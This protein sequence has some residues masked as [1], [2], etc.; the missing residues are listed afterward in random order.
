MTKLKNKLWILLAGA[1]VF[2]A[3]FLFA[4]FMAG[5]PVSAEETCTHEYG[6]GIIHAPTCT[7]E[8]YT[9][10]VCTLCGESY[11]DD[12][13]DRAE[14]AYSEVVIEPTCTHEG[15]TTHFCT[16]CG[17]EYTD[18]Y[19]AATGHTYQETTTLPTC[20]EEGYTTHTCL[21]CGYSFNDT[22]VA[23]L[24]HSYETE[25]IA[26]TCTEGGYTVYTCTVCE[27]THTGDETAAIGHAYALNTVEATCVTYGYT[28]HV[29]ANCS[30]RFVT[31]YI[32]ALGH[33]YEDEVIP[34]EDG[35]IGYTKHTCRR[36]DYSYLSDF[37]TSGDDGYIGDEEHA[38]AYVFQMENDEE[39]KC[40]RISYHC[41]CGEAY[42]GDIVILFTD[43][44]DIGTVLELAADGTADYSALKGTYRVT[45]T[46]AEGEL[47]ADFELT[48]GEAEEH[49][50]AYVFKLE[51][52]AE[53]RYFT[54]RYTCECGVAYNGA[55]YVSYATENGETGKLTANEEGVVD[56]SVLDG[57]C[58]ILIETETEVL[59]E[60]DLPAVQSPEEHTHAFVL[61][62]SDHA[63]ERY[64]TLRYVCECGE[65]YAGP[66][67][68]TYTAEDGETGTLAIDAEWKA[69]YSALAAG[70]YRIRVFADTE[71]ISEFEFRIQRSSTEPEQPGHGDETLDNGEDEQPTGEQKPGDENG[72]QTEEG[73][74]KNP[75]PT[76]AVLIVLL[77][78]L[79]ACGIAVFIAMK[80]KNKT[81]TK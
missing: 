3:V 47:L 77:G 78:V 71:Q 18:S 33:D 54:F 16:V 42:G 43:S 34:A 70:T 5:E 19:T 27:Y 32:A 37:V 55:V 76:L 6:E 9:E 46:D 23:A 40:L 22:Y 74:K 65:V 80:R 26:P 35:K 10:Y 13:T 7:A 31:D 49:V 39:R 21:E 14:H 25:V 58:H 56:Y 28:E 45:I 8:G 69:D 66:L 12:F 75:A 57:A 2:S 20:T 29:C 4:G 67:H 11:K 81:K 72:G 30:D 44:E 59:Y 24:G 15:Y 61:N 52:N 64:F 50:H 79:A 60:F 68:M 63:E 41:E 1:V 17:Y 62:I 38:H 73:E 36:C 51:D 53:E 48:N